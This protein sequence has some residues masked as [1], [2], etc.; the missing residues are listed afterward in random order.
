MKRKIIFARH[1]SRVILETYRDI[2]EISSYAE[3]YLITTDHLLTKDIKR[4][5]LEWKRKNLIKEII[6]FRRYFYNSGNFNLLKIL[7]NYFLIHPNLKKLSE[8]KIDLCIVGGNVSVWER[9]II[10]C[11]IKKDCKVVAYQSAMLTLPIKSIKE[12]YDSV[13]IEKIIKK[14]HKSRELKYPKLKSKKVDVSFYKKIVNYMNRKIDIIERKYIVRLFFNKTFLYRKLDLNT[15]MDCSEPRINKILTYFKTLQ[16]YWK[17]IY[18]QVDVI[19]IKRKNNCICKLNS[20]KKSILFLG[21]DILYE[22]KIKNKISKHLKRDLLTILSKFKSVKEIHFRPHP[23]SRLEDNER[24]ILDM[25]EY[26]SNKY[27]VRHMNNSRPLDEI[28]CQYKAVVG[29]FGTGLFNCEQSCKKIIPIGLSS[30]SQYYYDEGGK[31][32]KIKVKGTN[33]GVI[34]NDG[35]YRNSV[36]SRKQNIKNLLNLQ[37]VIKKLLIN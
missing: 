32:C 4:T 15:M 37:Q 6:I 20:V 29:S 12:L 33:I 16:I 17:K 26:L 13:P 1:S 21:D 25:N 28:A 31:D 10:E 22:E 27:K 34:E 36:F 3:I 11:I 18:P 8:E 23:G 7:T 19:Q 30:V 24:T 14:I 5:F 2:K 35:S 9:I